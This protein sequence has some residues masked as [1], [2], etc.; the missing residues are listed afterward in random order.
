M[1]L[2]VACAFGFC[3]LATGTPAPKQQKTRVRY[4]LLAFSLLIIS[5][6]ST[7]GCN[8]SPQISYIGALFNGQRGYKLPSTNFYFLI[9][10]VGIVIFLI[11]C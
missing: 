7:L 3:S 11:S 5:I 9:I 4:I 8:G 2:T 10:L 1:S 6:V